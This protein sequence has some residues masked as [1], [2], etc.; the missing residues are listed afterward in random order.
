[1]SLP[2]QPYESWVLIYLRGLGRQIACRPWS[3]PSYFDPKKS[4]R[5]EQ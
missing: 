3:L 1:V 2:F 4:R 5:V